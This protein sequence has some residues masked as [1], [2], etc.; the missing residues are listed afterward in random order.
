MNGINGPLDDLRARGGSRETTL[1]TMM[2]AGLASLLC[3]GCTVGGSDAAGASG[4]GPDGAAG[5]GAGG[6]SADVYVEA[7]DSAVPPIEGVWAQ[8]LVYAAINDIPA[9]GQMNGTTTTIQRLV[10]QRTGTSIAMTAEPCAIEIDNGTNVV[11][12]IIPDA[13]LR[14]LGITDRSGHLDRDAGTWRFLQDRKLQLRGV[15]LDQPETDPLPTDDADPRVWDQD[16]DNHPGVTVRITGL[17]D[18]EVY[19]VQRDIH[20]LEGVVQADRIDGLTDWSID[21]VVLGSDNPVL[22]MQT[23]SVKDPDASAS[24]FRSTRVDEATDCAAILA[25]RDTLFAR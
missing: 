5:Y 9:V 10:V 16:Q 14:S 22:D 23:S 21:Q 19:L 11:N 3:A 18:G 25:S 20:S 2:R 7:D 17:T 15:H 24:W 1:K 8:K 4:D 13:F 6:A 12:T